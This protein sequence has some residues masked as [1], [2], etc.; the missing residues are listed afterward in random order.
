VYIL[1]NTVRS[2]HPIWSCSTLSCK[3]KWMTQPHSI[4]SKI[5]MLDNVFTCL[6]TRL[7]HRYM[8]D[9]CACMSASI[10]HE[11][12]T[13]TSAVLP[14]TIIGSKICTKSQ[15]LALKI[16]KISGGNTPGSRTREGRPPTAPTPSKRQRC[17]DPGF[18]KRSPN[19][20]LPLHPS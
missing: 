1:Y 14:G 5:I 20:E 7:E 3:I 17:R 4:L 11:C 16:S 15:D 12:V 19:P 2:E 9:A 6:L 10:Y 18:Q 13:S 8:N